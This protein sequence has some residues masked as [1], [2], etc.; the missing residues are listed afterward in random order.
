MAY[1]SEDRVAR[2]RARAEE[3][4]TLAAYLKHPAMRAELIGLADGYDRMA[5][6][7]KQSVLNELSD[8]ET[9]QR[10]H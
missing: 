8:P 10:N 3:L 7:A 9:P 6:G 2:Y 5:D 4:R 1:N